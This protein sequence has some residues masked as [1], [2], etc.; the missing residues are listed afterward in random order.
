MNNQE[1]SKRRVDKIRE[2]EDYFGYEPMDLASVDT[3]EYHKWLCD[4]YP[5]TARNMEQPEL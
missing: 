4:G 2:L 1:R 3:N 5:M